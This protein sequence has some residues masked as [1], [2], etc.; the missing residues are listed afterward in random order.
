MRR[1]VVAEELP[2]VVGVELD[3]V[4]FL[5]DL[6]V[7]LWLALRHAGHETMEALVLSRARREALLQD[8]GDSLVTL[9]QACQEGLHVLIDW[10]LRTKDDVVVRSDV[11]PGRDDQ[12]PLDSSEAGGRPVLRKL[13]L[14]HLSF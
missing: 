11:R 13:R 10:R 6:L 9:C 5:R 14:V 8:L 1:L 3:F 4:F 7:V 2:L 12:V